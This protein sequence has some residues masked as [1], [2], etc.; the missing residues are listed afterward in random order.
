[1][2]SKHAEGS[3]MV[4]ALEGMLDAYAPLASA[5]VRENGWGALITPVMFA[6][7]ALAFVKETTAAVILA[8]LED[9]NA[10]RYDRDRKARV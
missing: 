7:T 3:G 4:Q 1:M 8:E 2:T 6:I 5:T 10:D 9:R